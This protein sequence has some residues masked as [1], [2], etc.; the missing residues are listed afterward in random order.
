PASLGNRLTFWLVV[1]L[2]ATVLL[3]G[4]PLVTAR[5]PARRASL[6]AFR[7]S[8]AASPLVP[9]G[10]RSAGAVQV[11]S[12]RRN[13]V[14]SGVLALATRPVLLP[15]NTLVV[16]LPASVLRSGNPL[17]TVLST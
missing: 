5:E 8:R 6:V 2:P 1:A 7:S 9:A 4:R 10:G 13:F 16:A 12:W 11:P 17:V 3:S 15:L 14:G